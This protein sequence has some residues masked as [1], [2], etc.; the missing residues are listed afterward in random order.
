MVNLDQIWTWATACYYIIAC[1]FSSM[2]ARPNFN[3]SIQ[4]GRYTVMLTFIHSISDSNGKGITWRG[5]RRGTIIICACK[6][7]ILSFSKFI[8][9]FVFIYHCLNP[10]RHHSD[11]PPSQIHPNPVHHPHTRSRSG[12]ETAPCLQKSHPKHYHSLWKPFGTAES[13]GTAACMR[14]LPLK[15]KRLIRCLHGFA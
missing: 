14:A 4:H 6:I 11:P 15:R 13:L 10:F 7:Y 9:I 5:Y 1:S 8:M 2:A 3:N 12:H